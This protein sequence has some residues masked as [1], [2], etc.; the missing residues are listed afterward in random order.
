[1]YNYLCAVYTR[2]RAAPLQQTGNTIEA[3]D[4]NSDAK[5]SRAVPAQYS[6]NVTTFLQMSLPSNILQN[7]VN[8]SSQSCLQLADSYAVRRQV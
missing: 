2:L 5:L 3:S 6:E 8:F 7:T 1:M 4:R